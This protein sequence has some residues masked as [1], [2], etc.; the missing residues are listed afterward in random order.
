M[1][2]KINLEEV[3]E[4]VKDGRDCKVEID[5]DGQAYVMAAEAAGYEDT[6]L[7]Q[8][9]DAYD[10]EECESEAQYTEWL[11]SCYIGEELEAKN[12]KKIEIEFTK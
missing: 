4:F 12:G 7:I 8:Q 6:I 3:M 5:A 10:Y 2:V 1:L 11:E 9:F